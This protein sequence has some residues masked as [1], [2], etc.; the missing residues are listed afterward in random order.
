MP[1]NPGNRVP[2]GSHAALAVQLLMLSPGRLNSSS[3]PFSV[4][5]LRW[6]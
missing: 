3:D 1:V 5:A 2:S 6:D 4:A